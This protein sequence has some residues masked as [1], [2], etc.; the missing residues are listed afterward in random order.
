M[1][2]LAHITSALA[3]KIPG[4]KHLQ[5]QV[6]IFIYIWYDPENDRCPQFS[7]SINVKQFNIF[8]EG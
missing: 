6:Q 2:W 4:I 3:D 1:I 8:I 5:L 7:T